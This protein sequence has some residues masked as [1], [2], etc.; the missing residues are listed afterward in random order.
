[1]DPKS[2][3]IQSKVKSIRSYENSKEIAEIY[4]LL[5]KNKRQIKEECKRF[6]VLHGGSLIISTENL[7][8]VLAKMFP[9]KLVTNN[10]RVIVSMGDKDR[11]SIIDVD[12]LFNQIGNSDR[13]TIS[14]PRC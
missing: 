6:F 7:L 12:Y 4:H 11:T 3:N 2:P 14:H 10:W 5:W 8:N 9:R 1:M 13:S